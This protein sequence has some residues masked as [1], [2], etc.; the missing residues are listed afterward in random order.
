M[1]YSYL[2]AFIFVSL[3]L[4]S[5]AK[6]S[7][8]MGG[9]RD[10]D[11][12]VVLEMYPKDQSL[13]QKPEEITIL[14][15]EYIKLENPN[16]NIIITPKLD[17]DELIITALKDMVKIELNQ[18]LEDSTTY[19][20]NFQK[21]IQ[22][23]SEGNPTENLKLV[24]ST[25]NSIDSLSFEGKVNNYFP[26]RTFTYE[27]VIVGLYESN[28]TT[29]V[30]TAQPY[31]L[32]QTDS[33]GNFVINNIKAGEYRA[34]AWNDDNNSLKAEYKS[35]DYDF[36]LD[37]LSINENL[38]GAVFNLSKADQTVINLTRSS[39][40]GTN[41]DI[42]FNKDPLDIEMS[43]EELGKT[44]FYTTGDKRIK[45]YSETPR[46]DSL[47]FDLE[48]QDSL[49]FRIDTTIYAKFEESQR[50]PENLTFTVNSGKSFYQDLGIELT[51]NKPISKIN[52]DSLYISYDTASVIPITPAMVS[53][54]DS[55]KRDKVEINLSLPDSLVTD[56][57]TINGT[58]STFQDIEG[59]FNESVLAA[60]YRKLKRET[61]AD[62]IT[63]GIANGK[64]PYIMHLLDSK[65]QIS[66]EKYIEEGN[67]FSF[68]LLEPGTYKIRVIED[69]NGNNRWDPSNYLEKRH[70]EKVYFFLNPE[71]Q[72]QDI[73]IKAGWTTEGI[74]INA[75]PNTGIQ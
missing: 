51:F 8:P 14:F 27:N 38:T 49:S 39:T 46:V 47:R 19:V 36:I 31:Y 40:S 45:L 7:T 69:L 34:Y 30:F 12:P 42:I 17:K 68:T 25:G 21:S 2:L 10:E 33:L 61:L 57:L 13:N 44:I 75:S 26:T 11:P 35:E 56:I 60:N 18:E 24:F 28:D 55:L 41:Y 43:N 67:K 3:I 1:K 15:D 29:D 59:Q 23:L 22:D 64:G 71:T 70:A 73:I 32:S 5:C 65:G 16:R 52:Y 58:D 66:R 53:L 74:I 48:I 54:T 9:P 63:G 72:S 62:S 50:R 6:Q 4:Y 37:T 20:F